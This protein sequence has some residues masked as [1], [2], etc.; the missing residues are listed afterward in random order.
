M[1]H[2]SGYADDEYSRQAIFQEGVCDPKHY[3]RIV[4]CGSDSYITHSAHLHR[5]RG[6]LDWQLILMAEGRGD[7]LLDGKMFRAKKG[8]WILLPPGI[9]NDYTYRQANQPEVFWIHFTGHGV[10]EV[11]RSAGLWGRSHF[12]SGMHPEFSVILNGI[13]R[14]LQMKR[15]YYPL[16]GMADF[17]GLTALLARR[18][19][20][21]QTG[22][23][24]AG[25]HDFIKVMARMQTLYNTDTSVCEYAREFGLSTNRFIHNFRQYTGVSPRRYITGIRMDKARYLLLNTTLP[26]GE[27]AR[28]TGYEN[29]FY[30]SRIFK[31]YSGQAP[32]AFRQSFGHSLAP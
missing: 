29:V 5:P 6:R 7:Y 32:L 28:V 24:E 12:Y 21:A 1:I 11:L 30:F 25:G 13:I 27:I 20:E 2:A 10:E 22:N 19:A 4:C 18:A 26:A 16:R 9:L 17:L 15:P 3:L 31:K 23:C 14:E 8:D